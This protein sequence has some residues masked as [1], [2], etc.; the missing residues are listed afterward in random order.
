[1]ATDQPLLPDN[2]MLFDEAPCGLVVTKEDGTILRSNQTFSHSIGLDAQALIGRRFQD[3]LTMGGRIFHQTHWSPLMQMQGSVAEVK[4]DLVHHDK[5]IVTMLLNGVRREHASGAFY[6]LALF[7]TKDRDKYE[8][9]LLNARKVA[10]DLLREK[11]AAESA[12]RQAQA[13][14]KSAYEEAQ[15]RASFA[16][17]M[18]AIVSHDL[19]NPLTAIKM[20]SGILAREERTTRE[21]KMLGHISQS[22]NRAERMIADLLDLALARVGQGIT[23]SPSTVDLH[24]FVGASVD[25]L[26][27]TF[28]EATLVHQTVGTGNAWLDADRVQ[29]IIGNLVANSVAYGDLQQPITITSRVEQDHAVVSVKNQGPVIPDSLMGVLFEPMI[30]GGNTGTDSRSVGLG[31]FIVRE[32]VRAHNGVVSVN[33]TP[34]SGTTFTATFPMV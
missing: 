12:L 1:M 25:E 33:S 16:E 19:K 30:R 11:T 10:E 18:V 20:A 7:G 8:R 31:L 5:H 21:S 28:P 3:L 32:I 14:L 26:R 2:Q 9:E 23:L 15:L 34:E 13:E 22:V 29:Q 17:Q 4:L 24:A 27:M 6:E